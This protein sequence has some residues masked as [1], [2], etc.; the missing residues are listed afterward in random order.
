M[1]KTKFG[2]VF[3]D[4]D[5]LDTFECECPNCPNRGVVVVTIDIRGGTVLCLKHAKR[6][7]AGLQAHIK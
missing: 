5:R 7:L 6:L 1:Q 2:V 3:Y 4:E